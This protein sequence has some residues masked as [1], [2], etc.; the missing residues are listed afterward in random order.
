MLL[1][2]TPLFL[3]QQL[4]LLLNWVMLFKRLRPLIISFT[5]KPNEID[6]KANIDLDLFDVVV[7]DHDIETEAGIVTTHLKYLYPKRKLKE[8]ALLF[9]F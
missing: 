7:K 2:L 5:S 8:L 4:L 1:S 6:K 3:N 9:F